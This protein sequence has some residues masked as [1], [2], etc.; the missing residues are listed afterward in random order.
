MGQALIRALRQGGTSLTI[1]NRTLSKAEQLVQSGVT[2]AKSAD[3]A[4]TASSCSILCVADYKTG[5]ELLTNHNRPSVDC[6]IIQLT[7]GKPVD[8]RG[9]AG[10]VHENK[11]SYLDGSIMGFPNHVG[12]SDNRILYSGDSTAFNSQQ[13]RLEMLGKTRYLGENPGAAAAL[14]LG[15]LMPIMPM[16]VGLVQ[17]M[18][19]CKAEGVSDQQYDSFIRE[20]VPLV[21]EDTLAKAR[22]VGYAADPTKAEVS[23][24][25]ATEVSQMFAEY[26]SEVDTDPSIFRALEHLFQS[27]VDQGLKDYDWVYAAELRVK[28]EAGKALPQESETSRK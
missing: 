2:V 22:Q 24:L 10:L 8:A 26:C 17:G 9:L 27:G 11:G 1:W 20:W 15:A 16:V 12:T 23:L 13:R 19:A 6:T 3:E 4:L 25:Q 18:K 5:R 14:D 21:L 7:T 28:G